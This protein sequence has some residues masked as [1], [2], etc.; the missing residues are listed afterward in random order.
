MLEEQKMEM[1]QIEA[2]EENKITA[3]V[4]IPYFM[5]NDELDD[6]VRTEWQT[7]FHEIARYYMKYK[8]GA[9]F[10]AEGS[11]GDYVPSNLRYKK[12]AMIL[13]KEA[14]FA[15]ANPPT[16]NINQKDVDTKYKEENAI[17]Q[18]YLD[19]VLEKTNFNGK[20]LKALKDCF[21]GKRIAIVVN[22]N[23]ETG[24]TVTFLNS[25]EFIYESSGKDDD[26]LTK[27]VSFYKMNKTQQ[28]QEQ[29]W[30]KKKYILA[31]GIELKLLQIIS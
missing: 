27:F 31:L 30:F 22:F 11:N 9:N 7:E 16:F 25:L 3:Y 14:R 5:L 15:F 2:D 29:R 18:T 26:N 24:I 20:V 19:K 6:A 17:L 28:L 23:E 10:I 8:N 13:N 12:A 4:N 21:I 1:Q